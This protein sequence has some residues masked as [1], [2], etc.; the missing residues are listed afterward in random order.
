MR[1]LMALEKNP[2][3]ILEATLCVDSFVGH[4]DTWNVIA[5]TRG[6][7]HSNVVFLGAY[8]DWRQESRD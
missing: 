4:V 6:G 5:E 2:S 8:S 7:D 3:E 1:Y